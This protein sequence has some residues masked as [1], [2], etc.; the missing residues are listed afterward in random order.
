MAAGGPP[1]ETMN[2]RALLRLACTLPA[3]AAGAFGPGVLGAAPRPARIGY[4][5]QSPMIDPPSRE[6]A[7]FLDELG[8]LGYRLGE[9]LLIEYRSAENEPEFLPDLARELV[10]MKVDVIVATGGPPASAAK[11]AT[12]DIPIVFTQFPDPVGSGLVDSLR[13]PGANV[14]GISFVAPDLAGKRLQLLRELLPGAKKVAMLWGMP[15]AEA[16][17]ATTRTRAQDFGL[18]IDSHRLAEADGLVE[19]LERIGRGR[20]DA[21]LVVG[22]L[23]MVSYRD[24]VIEMARRHRRPTVAGWGDFVRAGGLISYA[25]NFPALFRRSAHLVDRI[26]RGARPRDIPVEQ[27]NEFELVVNLRTADALGIAVPPSIL[28]RADALIR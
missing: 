28:V 26:L 11:A 12:R 1:S 20:P 21:L 17:L 7:A 27:P 4:L 2:R 19:R 23:K 3:I 13:E 22:D 24:L 18:V 10:R 8:K 6:R 9:D 5:V 25:P 16:E 14:T 15:D